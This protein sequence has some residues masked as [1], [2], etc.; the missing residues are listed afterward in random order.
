MIIGTLAL[1]AVLM[2]GAGADSWST[3]A[4]KEIKHVIEDK[5]RREKA[6]AILER[7]QVAM[8]S[9]LETVIACRKELMAV[10]MR[11]ESTVADFRAAYAKLEKI[12]RDTENDLLMLR[13]ELRDLL[14]RAEWDDLCRR[15]DAERED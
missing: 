14:T 11:Y 4:N 3:L 5:A 13:F 2:H 6:N 10:E 9:H 7:M 8:G 1:I 12:W 15:V